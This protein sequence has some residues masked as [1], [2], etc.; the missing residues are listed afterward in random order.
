[1]F[2]FIEGNGEDCGLKVLIQVFLC[3][4]SDAYFFAELKKERR[5][6]QQDLEA[7]N[8][9]NESTCTDKPK[10]DFSQIPSRSDWKSCHKTGSVSYHLTIYIYINDKK[11][12]Y[13]ISVW[14]YCM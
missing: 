5:L 7:L 3:H 4:F 9:L 2:L 14:I 10:P 8:L 6:I 1:M 13:P 11:P 12:L